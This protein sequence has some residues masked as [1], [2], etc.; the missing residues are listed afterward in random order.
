MIHMS[1]GH[2]VR[3]RAPALRGLAFIALLVSTIYA[4]GPLWVSHDSADAQTTV[5]FVTNLT[6]GTDGIPQPLVGN[7]PDDQS[8]ETIGC[9][10]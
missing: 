3:R 1:I 9:K 6:G 5:N 2:V 4:A 7:I 10:S 8:M